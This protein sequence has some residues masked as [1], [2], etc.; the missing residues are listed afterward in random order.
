MSAGQVEKLADWLKAGCAGR[1]DYMHRNFAKRIDPS[2]LLEGAKS[3]II[4]GLNYNPPPRPSS[5]AP[6]GKVAN[7]ARYEDYHPFIKKRL[8]RL[9]DFIISIVGENLQFRLCVD[10]APL[11]ERAFAVRAG[12]GFIG[13]NHMLI[14]PKLGCQI[15]LGE[16]ITNL[17]LQTDGPIT[18]DCSSCN[19]CVD[20]CPTG[21]LR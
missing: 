17:K 10:S 15:F 14:N 4:V 5:L 13:K 1:L 3:L 9:T 18:A 20:A 6:T 11:A 7:Y 21:A 2:G 16:I 8:H 12:L 19:K